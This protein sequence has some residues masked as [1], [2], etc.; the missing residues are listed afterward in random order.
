MGSPPLRNDVA[1]RWVG[2]VRRDLLDH[3]I[4]LNKR[5]RRRL[6]PESIRYAGGSTFRKS[7]MRSVVVD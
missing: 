7:Q 5:H 4:P 3:V 6:L 1:E 2:S